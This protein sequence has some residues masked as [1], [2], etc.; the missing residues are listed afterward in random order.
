MFGM[1]YLGATSKILGPNGEPGRMYKKLTGQTIPAGTDGQFYVMTHVYN[2]LQAA[3]P[4]ITPASSGAGAFTIPSNSGAP[5]FAA[6]YW[7]FQDGDDGT[8]GAHDH[9]LV[10]DAREVYWRGDVRSTGD[11]KAGTYVATYD[12][13]RFRNGE[14]PAE[15][16][17]VYP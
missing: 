9:T 14:W 8:P 3:G 12:G 1:S 17:P 10:D 13:K 2:L 4:R 5:D 7:S 15:D 16:P 11:G 6:G